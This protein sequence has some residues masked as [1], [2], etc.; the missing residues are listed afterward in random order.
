ML[1]ILFVGGNRKDVSAIKDLPIE[2]DYVQNGM[3]ALSALNSE[4]YDGVVIHDKLPLL[5]PSRLVREIRAVNKHIPIYNLIQS[6]ERRSEIL[7]DLA[8]GATFYF[9]PDSQSLDLLLEMILMGK[10]YYDF[11]AEISEVERQFFNHIGSGSIIGI[12]ELMINL[13]RLLSQIRKKDVTTILYG[14][15]GTGKNLVASWLHDYSLRK[16]NPSISVNC[17]AIPKELLES[18]LFGHTKGAFTGADSDKD[19]KFQA[20]NSGTIF[21]DEI[22]DLDM[23]LQAKI[24]RV[25][26]SGEVEKIGANNSIKVDV[27][28]ISATNQNLPEMVDE[29]KFRQ[30][31]FHRINVF[32][33]TV[34]SLSDHPGDIPLIAYSILRQLIKKHNSPINYISSD[35]LRF[36]KNYDWPGN[37]RELENIM[38]RAILTSQDQ[39]LS[40]ADLES[41]ISVD[42]PAQQVS[43]PIVE[44]VLKADDDHQDEIKAESINVQESVEETIPS[45]IVP[46]GLQSLKALE[47]DAIKKTLIHT[48]YNMSKASKILGIS[49]MT[50]YRKIETYGLNSDE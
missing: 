41:L 24:L 37:V 3:I 47:K 50:L 22:G 17:P 31:L 36:L 26:E 28:I 27:R 23:N 25:L 13:Y 46:S 19:G 34:P 40:L 33:I 30:D 5:P 48:K 21:L 45:N 2:L 12:S 6:S 38:E 14:N 10:Q 42:H 9:E 8:N 11:M 49:R 20:A 39:E 16:N 43:E 7:S 15:S 44:E 29:K 1:D 18:E 4:Y 32:P 35:G